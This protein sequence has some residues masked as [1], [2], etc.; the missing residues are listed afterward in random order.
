MKKRKT[1]GSLVIFALLFISCTNPFFKDFLVSENSTTNPNKTNAQ[2]P[3]ISF[4]SDSEITVLLN[5]IVNISTVPKH[6]K[7]I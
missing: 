3:K 1:L 4:H 5:G 6:P 2:V 7:F